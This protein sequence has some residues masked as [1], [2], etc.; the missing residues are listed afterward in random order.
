MVGQTYCDF[1]GVELE[2]GREFVYQYESLNF[3]DDETILAAI[4]NSGA[5]YGEPLRLCTG[6][7]DSIQRNKR[8]LDLEYEEYLER[9]RVARTLFKIAFAIIGLIVLIS[10]LL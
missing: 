10:W 2:P 7:N 6:C 4:R 3:V 5:Y 8:D 1:C 9:A